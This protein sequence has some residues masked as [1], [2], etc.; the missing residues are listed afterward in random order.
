MVAYIIR[1]LLLIVPTLIGFMVINFVIINVAH[2][3]PIEQLIANLRGEGGGITERVAATEGREVRGE[4]EPG[5]TQGSQ[6]EQSRAGRGLD[7]ELLKKLRAQLH[8]DKP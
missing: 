7:P 6:A 3:G 2:G 1:R 5:G 8:L 4:R